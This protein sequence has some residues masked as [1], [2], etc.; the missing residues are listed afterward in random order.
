MEAD[1][2]FSEV[3]FSTLAMSPGLTFSIG[4]MPGYVFRVKRDA[5]TSK[6]IGAAVSA[7]VVV[8]FAE[9]VSGQGG[10]LAVMSGS[11][12]PVLYAV[13]GAV[14]MIAESVDRMSKEGALDKTLWADLTDPARLS[15][16][17]SR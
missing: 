17:L 13:N 9:C 15:A 11:D 12:G 16:L 14:L 2:A 10:A 7:V 1:C 6:A 4:N 3:P 8:G 5:A